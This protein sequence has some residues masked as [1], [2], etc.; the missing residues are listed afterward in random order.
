MHSELSSKPSG[1]GY[2]SKDARS[3]SNNSYVEESDVQKKY[4]MRENLKYEHRSSMHQDQPTMNRGGDTYVMRNYPPENQRVRASKPVDRFPPKT[5]NSFYERSRNSETYKNLRHEVYRSDHIR[6][7]Q[8]IDYNSVMDEFYGAFALLGHRRYS[9]GEIILRKD[10]MRTDVYFIVS[11][12][13]HMVDS[14]GQLVSVLGDREFFGE[15][16]MFYGIPS[17]FNITAAEQGCKLYQ[18]S[19]SSLESLFQNPQYTDI[20]N[21]LK[22]K[23]EDRKH[24]VE[25]RAR[26]EESESREKTQG[27]KH[28]DHDYIERDY[29]YENEREH[30]YN[31]RERDYYNDWEQYNHDH[32]CGT[33]YYRNPRSVESNSSHGYREPEAQNCESPAC[34]NYATT[35]YAPHSIAYKHSPNQHR[36]LDSEYFHPRL[37]SAHTKSTTSNQ[38]SSQSPYYQARH[39]SMGT[40]PQRGS[41][42][43]RSVYDKSHERRV[44]EDRISFADS[45]QAELE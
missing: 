29:D 6:Q 15:L 8:D 10:D 37:T 14:E 32:D 22:R 7:L 35:E 20:L 1:Y 43:S 19:K 9:P 44:A 18:V 17:P 39:H 31:E 42:Y 13:V 38:S 45:I 34:D 16:G 4:T 2:T 24:I 36:S 11:G 41:Q 40:I 30:G 3:F 12:C 27:I 5:K 25:R 28:Y 23:C 33:Q 21:I 26:I